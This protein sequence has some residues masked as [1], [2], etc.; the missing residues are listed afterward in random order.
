MFS[1]R[2]C[3][4]THVVAEAVEVVASG[5]L[6]QIERWGELLRKAKIQFEV[7]RFCDEHR[8]TRINHVELWVDR[9][10]VERA[11]SAIRNDKAAD[12]SLMW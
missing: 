9:Y 1:R 12:R 6:T 4:M 10:A 8:P 2:E 5:T 11:R 3:V 7:R